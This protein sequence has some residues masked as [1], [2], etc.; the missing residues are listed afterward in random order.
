MEKLKTLQKETGL[1]PT[2]KAK[3]L[4]EVEEAK[5]KEEQ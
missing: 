2:T 1:D 4:K 3:E 5:A